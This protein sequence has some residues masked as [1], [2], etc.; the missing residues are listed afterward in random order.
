MRAAMDGLSKPHFSNSR[1]V[2]F[3]LSFEG[4]GLGIKK[5]GYAGHVLF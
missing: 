5:C 4:R 3:F 2:G 1:E